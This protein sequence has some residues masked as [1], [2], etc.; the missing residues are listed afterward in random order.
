MGTTARD[1]AIVQTLC[2]LF[3][4]SPSTLTAFTKL[5]PRV[6]ETFL[7]LGSPARLSVNAALMEGSFEPKLKHLIAE[8]DDFVRSSFFWAADGAM[9]LCMRD[10]VAKD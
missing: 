8:S 1:L 7:V 5:V 4:A 2:S 3:I 6:F 9:G 10:R